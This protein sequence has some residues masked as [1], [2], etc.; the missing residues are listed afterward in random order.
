MEMQWIGSVMDSPNHAEHVRNS[1]SVYYQQHFSQLRWVINAFLFAGY[2]DG[3]T[4][5]WL[6]AM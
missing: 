5:A 2:H 6:H 4:S 1:L 3:T